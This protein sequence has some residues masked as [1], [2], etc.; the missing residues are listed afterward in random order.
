MTAAVDDSTQVFSFYRFIP[1]DRLSER[2]QALLARAA[3]AD[4]LGTV[5]LAPEGINATLCGPRN[6]VEDLLRWLRAE[7][8]FDDLGGRWS[9]AVEPPF[10]KLKVRLRD[11]IVTLG[12]PGLDPASRTGRRVGPAG[13]NRLLDDPGTRIIDTRNDY[14]VDVGRFPG[15]I[16]PA[17]ASFRDFPDFAE[18][19]IAELRRHRVAMYCTGGIRCEKASALLLA[20]GCPEVVQ[21][22]GGIL[23][24]L[25][26]VGRRDNRWQGECFV[27][28]ARV[29]VD[30]DLKPGHYL[31]CHACRRPLGPTDIAAPEYEPGIAC[32]AC[33][34]TLSPAKRAALAERRRQDALKAAATVPARG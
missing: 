2:R 1:L 33:H 8:G 30:A 3:A 29:A 15:A 21:L 12:R 10:R 26:T 11:E 9:A 28:D 25:E 34:D 31:Q 13:W 32:P 24:Y 7:F 20:L 18:A 22:D 4:V 23:A 19:N 16:N 5:L 6:A 17:T 27:F 14:E